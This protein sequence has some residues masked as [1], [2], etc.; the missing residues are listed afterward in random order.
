MGSEP[1]RI[2]MGVNESSIKGYPHPSISSRTAF[3]W[4]IEKIVR[5]NARGF[6]IL[7]IHVQIPDEDGNSYHL[8]R[9]LGLGFHSL[10]SCSEL[11]WCLKFWNPKLISVH[12]LNVET[13]TECKISGGLWIILLIRIWC[14]I[15]GD[16]WIWVLFYL[17]FVIWQWNPFVD[18]D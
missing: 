15:S 11:S 4:T 2:L 14:K 17:S 10:V 5:D 12:L 16:L 3:E 9:S 6:K 18:G 13:V 8:S 7:F 1:T